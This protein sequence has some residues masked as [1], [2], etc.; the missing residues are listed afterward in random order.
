MKVERK[1]SVLY[2]HITSELSVNLLYF[3]A[4]RCYV[5]QN[6]V[7]LMAWE[8]HEEREIMSN[9][10]EAVLFIDNICFK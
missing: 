4:H 5:E 8:V 1:L 6:S 3:V 9:A 2:Q 7:L 10:T